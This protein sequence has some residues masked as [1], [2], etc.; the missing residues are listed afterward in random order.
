MPHKLLIV[1]HS[2]FYRLRLTHILTASE[3]LQVTGLAQSEFDAQRI[4]SERRVDVVVL[5][6]DMPSMEGLNLLR[7]IMKNSPLPVVACTSST[8]RE[9]ILQAL[10]AGAIDFI[11]KPELRDAMRSDEFALQLRRKVEAA[12]EAFRQKVSDESGRPRPAMSL[13]QLNER[14]TG[15]PRP[16]LVGIVGSAGGPAAV[17]RIASELPNDIRVPIIVAVHM[18]NGFTRSFSDRLSRRSSVPVSE[19]QDGEKIMEGRVLIAPGGQQTIVERDESGLITR[20]YGPSSTDLYAPCADQLLSS[21]AKSC[22][23]ATLCTVLT[24]MGT[25]GVEGAREIHE[26]GGSVIVE[27]RES[28]VIWGMPRAV[29]EAGLADAELDLSSI[30]TALSSLTRDS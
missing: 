27:S 24:G 16:K 29:L 10:E 3:S 6:L 13:S 20:V 11:N 2:P 15:R 9:I 1:D 22:E 8:D 12:G 23:A 26:K 18:P 5:D 4:I 14:L 30:C 21:I 25:D 19:A 28:A 7:W 17:T